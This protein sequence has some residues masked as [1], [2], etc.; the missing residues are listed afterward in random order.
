MRSGR[1]ESKVLFSPDFICKHF[2]VF[3]F[4]E[5]PEEAQAD[6]LLNV[7]FLIAVCNKFLQKPVPAN[8]LL[9]DILESLRDTEAAPLKRQDCRVG[10]LVEEIGEQFLG[11]AQRQQYLDAQTGLR[12]QGLAKLCYGELAV[13]S[14]YCEKH[15]EALVFVMLYANYEAPSFNVL[16]EV[17]AGL[18][19]Q[20]D[21]RLRTEVR[22]KL[23]EL[24]DRCFEHFEQRYEQAQTDQGRF[25]AFQQTAFLGSFLE[26]KL[27]RPTAEC[28][29]L[30]KLER[31]SKLLE[32]T[33]QTDNNVLTFNLG[34]LNENEDDPLCAHF[35][36]NYNAWMQ[37]YLKLSQ[38]SSLQL[39]I[40]ALLISINLNFDNQMC[41]N[42]LG[43][44]MLKNGFVKFGLQA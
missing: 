17:L 39:K 29:F 3:F 36:L 19:D 2:P 33:E 7:K 9:Q 13:L 43:R 8:S 15:V 38:T 31:F 6:L 21:E 22:G 23:E 37:Y 40:A 35:S 20:F 41:W 10:A 14:L 1:L 44:F 4:E 32:H 26:Y 25:E 28:R 27:R 16:F 12:A 11:E 18:W 30:G 42:L 24:V 5:L 34:V